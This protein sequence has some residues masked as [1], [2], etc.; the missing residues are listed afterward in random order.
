[1]DA[2]VSWHGGLSFTGTSDSGFRLPLGTDRSVGGNEDGLRPMELFAIGLAGC[3]AMDVI[4]I[5]LKK[6]QDVTDFEVQVH[7][8]RASQHPK[9]FTQAVIEY[10]ITGREIDETA[11]QR[12]IELSAAAYCPAQAM[13]GKIMPIELKYTIYE[14]QDDGQRSLVKSAD[15]IVA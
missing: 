15:L 10:I 9:V 12:S 11:L 7:A 2:K 13:L 3:T 14:Q 8:D 4:S 6:R 5:L 1:V